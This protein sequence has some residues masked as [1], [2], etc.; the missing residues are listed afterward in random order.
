[1]NLRLNIGETDPGQQR[2]EKKKPTHGLLKYLQNPSPSISAHQYSM[3]TAKN[4]Y[5]DDRNTDLE[6]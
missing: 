1:M 2:R 4:P 6:T 3:F 5:L